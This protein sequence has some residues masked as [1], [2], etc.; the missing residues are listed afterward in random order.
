[1]VFESSSGEGDD[2]FALPAFT[3]A[4]ELSFVCGD[5]EGAVLEGSAGETVAGLG[6]MISTKRPH[7]L[8]LDGGSVTLTGIGFDVG[9]V[10]G[11]IVGGPEGVSDP[12]PVGV[13]V[14]TADEGNAVGLVLPASPK[15]APDGEAEGGEAEG[16]VDGAPEPPPV[17]TGVSDG[18][19]DG[20]RVG[21]R[22]STPAS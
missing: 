3:G 8:P 21:S 18:A 2:E 11:M 9:T 22:L 5:K 4:D 13:P 1:V 10:V 15:V 7:P 12:T 16:A 14:R 19:P 17:G 20:A 6:R